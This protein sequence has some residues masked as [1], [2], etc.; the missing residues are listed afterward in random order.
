M[1][2]R[3]LCFA[4]VSPVRR[5]RW[6]IETGYLSRGRTEGPSD[7]GKAPAWTLVIES[8]HTLLRTRLGTCNR[9]LNGPS[10]R[11]HFYWSTE[12]CSRTCSVSERCCRTDAEWNAV[13]HVSRPGTWATGREAVQ[14]RHGL[15][16]VF[17][18][19]AWPVESLTMYARRDHL[20]LRR[21]NMKKM[22]KIKNRKDVDKSKWSVL[23]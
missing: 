14:S 17:S 21:K 20:W 3:V 12:S 10:R 1:G 13:S 5:L 8:G 19:R 2:E 4:C 22:K 16:P 11:Q 9:D 15:L 6:A 23:L 18:A 7:E